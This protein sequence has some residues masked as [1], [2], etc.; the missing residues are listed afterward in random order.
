MQGSVAPKFKPGITST[1]VSNTRGPQQRPVDLNS[2]VASARSVRKHAHP[3]KRRTDE[4]KGFT[5]RYSDRLV[6]IAET[7]GPAGV[8]N[9]TNSNTNNERPTPV[10]VRKKRKNRAL[11]EIRVLQSTT[12]LL[13]RYAFFSA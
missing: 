7:A 2:S 12:N 13:L 3:P 8:P 5:Y 11:M 6:R 1:P 9:A 4:D 10:V